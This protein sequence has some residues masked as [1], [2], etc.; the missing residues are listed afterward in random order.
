MRNG[1]CP[2]LMFRRETGAQRRSK[3]LHG[4]GETVSTVSIVFLFDV[5]QLGVSVKVRDSVC[6]A[7]LDRLPSLCRK[8]G[9]R[10]VQK[11]FTHG[12]V[13]IVSIVIPVDINWL[14]VL[15]LRC[16]AEFLLIALVLQSHYTAVLRTFNIF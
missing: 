10:K 11:G 5:S 3:Q 8:L 7:A 6:I 15:V 9:S 4:D 13:L 14:S 16:F 12:N 1:S 2:R